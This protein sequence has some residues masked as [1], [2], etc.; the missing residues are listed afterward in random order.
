MESYPLLIT[1]VAPARLIREPHRESDLPI[2]RNGPPGTF[3]VFPHGLRVSL[4]TDQVVYA[5]DAEGV[6]TVGFGGMAF[7]GV[8]D[9]QLV[10]LRVRDL[11][12]EAQLSPDR[13]HRMQLNPAWVASIDEHAHRVWPPLRDQVLQ[14]RRPNP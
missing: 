14:F 3:V 5:N 10:C 9:G 4:P 2:T 6:V 11:L 7:S 12:P 1:L 8:E 13:S